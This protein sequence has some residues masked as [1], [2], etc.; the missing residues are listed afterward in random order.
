M[1]GEIDQLRG[2]LAEIARIMDGVSGQPT[3]GYLDV[4]GDTGLP[5]LDHIRLEVSLT[6][7]RRRLSGFTV[8]PY[9]LGPSTATGLRFEPVYGLAP[10]TADRA[11]QVR[12]EVSG[13]VVA[14]PPAG[15]DGSGTP[16]AEL[17][18]RRVPLVHLAEAA[19]KTADPV[20]LCGR[21]V[22]EPFLVRRAEYLRLVGNLPGDGATVVLHVSSGTM[23]AEVA[24]A[25]AAVIRRSD[26]KVW[27]VPADVTALDLLAAVHTADLVVTDAPALAA[28]AGGL[29]RSVIGVVGADGEFADWATQAGLALARPSELVAVAGDIGARDI[30]RIREGL[31]KALDLA[32]DEL[33]GSLVT[34]ASTELARGFPERIAEMARRAAALEEVNDGLRAALTRERTLVPHGVAGTDESSAGGVTD[35]RALRLRQA[36]VEAEAEVEHLHE[37]IDR[38]YSTRLMRTVGPVRRVYSRLRARIR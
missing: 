36:L 30:D 3:V 33:A 2:R 32:Y 34:I 13:L 23:A 10:W 24:A 21:T 11:D 16:V 25:V 8:R 7:L 35:T 5:A 22:E 4:P 20:A 9:S 15:S 18:A 31:V 38:I 17:S 28:L 6:E 37:E 29:S 12:S 19:G 27:T 1:G 14:A 26:R